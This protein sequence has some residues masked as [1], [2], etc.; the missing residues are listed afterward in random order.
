[1]Q[2]I[3]DDKK[4]ILSHAK[5]TDKLG[6]IIEGIKKF[7]HDHNRALLSI[8]IDDEFVD[9][10][11]GKPLKNKKVKD[12]KK[13]IVKT[14]P[15]D[16]ISGSTLTEIKKHFPLFKKSFEE[17][18]LLVQ[19]RNVKT[20]L[21]KFIKIIDEWQQL[22]EAFINS[23][24]IIYFDVNQKLVGKTSVKMFMDEMN[25]LYKELTGAFENEDWIL[26]ADLLEYEISPK[27]E[28]FGKLV[29]KLIKDTKE[30]AKA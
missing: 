11:S 7:V 13:L 21:E 27:M 5:D 25:K 1:M 24:K 19:E 6:E 23:L 30:K 10:S 14:C 29:N 26:L 28:E 22:N 3:I 15:K 18:A 9:E 12:F 16:L 4:D 2:I 17:I 20:A 8:K